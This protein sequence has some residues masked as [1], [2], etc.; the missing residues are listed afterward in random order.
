MS[1]AT[2]KKKTNAKYNNLSVGQG[3]SLNGVH[4]NQG[5]IGQT[6]LSRTIIGTPMKGSAPKGHGG[7]CGTYLN[8]IVKPALCLE[9]S[10]MVKRSVLSSNGMLRLRNKWLNGKSTVKPDVNQNNNIASMATVMKR[11]KAINELKNNVIK[12]QR[13]TGKSSL[14]GKGEEYI[15]G[16]EMYLTSSDLEL[17]NDNGV[18]QIVGTCFD[19]VN[20][21]KN[22]VINSANIKFIVDEI[23][24]GTTYL[25]LKVYGDNS[26]NPALP[27]L[28]SGDFSGRPQTNSISWEADNIGS[29][30]SSYYTCDISSIL[31]ELVNNE[32]W[33][34]NG[35]VCIFFERQEGDGVRCVES[36]F[37]ELNWDYNNAQ[38]Y[39]CNPLTD[40]NTNLLSY[41]EQ[42][43]SME[44]NKYILKKTS[45]CILNDPVQLQSSI[46]K[47]PLPSQTPK[48]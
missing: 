2:L 47:R 30:G 3:F 15:N 24:S 18:Y 11:R 45:E 22:S 13:I 10:E 43:G 42:I 4:R 46:D 29:V 9:K 27:S 14:S 32:G 21:P 25:K 31:Q 26:M 16:G 7:C 35:R 8:K 38:N 28:T 17:G 5:Y 37:A 39:D 6:S 41:V 19:N 40:P 23:K 44:Q 20:I 48:I 36:N 1:L 33:N 12:I 34:T